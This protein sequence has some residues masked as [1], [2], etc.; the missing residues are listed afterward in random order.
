MSVGASSAVE[1][2]WIPP[3]PSAIACE[4]IRYP[5]DPLPEWLRGSLGATRPLPLIAPELICDRF[6]GEKD[7]LAGNRRG[8][9]R[10]NQ[11]PRRQ[12]AEGV[13]AKT[14]ASQANSRGV[15]GQNHRLAGKRPRCSWRKRSPRRHTGE[16][17]MEKKIAAQAH[18][19]G[20]DGQKVASQAIQGGVDR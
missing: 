20:V 6:D 18:G 11:L 12:M 4:P 17:F 10:R 15:H 2:A 8:A 7:W 19:R 14:I 5:L 3:S 1:R 13:M 16:A 9:W